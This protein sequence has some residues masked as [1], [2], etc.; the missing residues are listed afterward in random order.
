MAGLY[1]ILTTTEA[2]KLLARALWYVEAHPSD[3]EP[4]AAPE[5][6]T[7]DRP[8]QVPLSRLPFHRV[9]LAGASGLP[10]EGAEG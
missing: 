6:R 10:P 8:G 4:V 2:L 7:E 3:V 1:S 5:R 9:S